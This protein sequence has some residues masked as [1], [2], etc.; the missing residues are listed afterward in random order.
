MLGRKANKKGIVDSRP[1]VSMTDIGKILGLSRATVYRRIERGRLSLEG[2]PVLVTR[3]VNLYDME[4][5]FERVF[6]SADKNT[7]NM[8]MFQFLQANRKV[9]Q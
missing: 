1:T 8:M 7:I 2:I 9:R 4:A 6:P 3:N 5:V